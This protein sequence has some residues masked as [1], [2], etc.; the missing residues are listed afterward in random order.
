MT[1]E[2]STS[3]SEDTSLTLSAEQTA[4]LSM[5][6]ATV[7]SA[8]HECISTASLLDGFAARYGFLYADDDPDR[9]MENYPI[10]KLRKHVPELHK[11]WTRMWAPWDSATELTFGADAGQTAGD[12]SQSAE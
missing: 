4:A 5:L 7:P 12:L 6:C 11:A 10:M 9:P 8:R 2:A 1:D 3:G